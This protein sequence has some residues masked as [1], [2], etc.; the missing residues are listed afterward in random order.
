ML[1]LILRFSFQDFHSTLSESW[2]MYQSNRDIST[3]IDQTSSETPPTVLQRSQGRRLDQFSSLAP[4]KH[5]GL[6]NSKAEVPL[7]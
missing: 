5:R 2:M 6:W 7:L 1:V 3:R 4:N